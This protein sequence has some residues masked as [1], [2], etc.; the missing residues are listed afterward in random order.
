MKVSFIKED[1]KDTLK[2]NVQANAEMYANAT[3]EWVIDF[4]GENPFVEYKKTF[5]EFDFDMSYEKPTESDYINAMKLHMALEDLSRSD[6]TDER[7]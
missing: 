7:F 2:A 3:P 4:I 6:A 5:T 1:A